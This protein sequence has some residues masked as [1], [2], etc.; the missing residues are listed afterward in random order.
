V[1]SNTP[2][3]PTPKQAAV[4]EQQFN[5]CRWLHNTALE[6]R[7][8]SFKAGKPVSYKVQANELPEIKEAFPEFGCVHS[9]VLQDGLKRLD[10]SF[11]NFFRR[12]KQGETPGFPRFKGKDRFHCITYPQSGFGITGSRIYL[13]GIGKVR[14]RVHRDIMKDAKVKTCTIKKSGNQWYCI[15][16]VEIA[17]TSIPKKV[18]SSA[19]GID[20]GLENF[21]TLSNGEIIS[22]PRHLRKSE[23][24]LK[25]IQCVYSIKKSKAKGRKL[26]KLHRKI[27]N[28]R[29]DFLHKQSRG[30]VNRFD[31]IA[32][33]DLNIKGMSKRC[34]SVE[35]EDGSFAPNGQSA[36][37]GL[38]KSINDAAW[39][40]FI[41]MVI[42]KV[43]DTGKYAVAINPRNTSQ[44]CSNCGALEKK[45]LSQRVHNCSVCGYAV[46]RDLN[47]AHNI[48][49]LGTDL[50]KE[51]YA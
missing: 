37:S 13:S 41:A 7:I 10:K 25:E 3:Y 44:I 48:L 32:Y 8:T 6:H 46:H 38:N 9:Q 24:R 40:K 26:T 39:G 4:I 18:V 15:L 35:N 47:S 29:N 36:K 20:L 49:R 31:L 21:A 42:Y 34:R 19:V 33:E 27:V 2:L 22:N 50:L 23:E 1:P 12:V 43:E 30:L 5:L 14:L 28:Q 17:N 11:Q 45:K 16:G 51:G